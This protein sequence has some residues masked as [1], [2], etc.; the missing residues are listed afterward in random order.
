MMTFLELYQTL[1]GFT[2]FRLYSE[3]NLIYPPKLDTAIDEGAGGL[4]SLLLEET[5]KTLTIEG[6]RDTE[7]GL[8]EGKKVTA[9]DVKKQIR[10]LTHQQQAS[11]NGSATTVEVDMEVE[12]S[13]A[14]DTDALIASEQAGPSEFPKPLEGGDDA[15]LATEEDASNLFEGYYF[16][17]SRE[18]TR[19]TLEFI[20]RSFG[21]QVGWDAILGSGSPY[22]INDPRITHHIVDRPVPAG[23]PS[24][25]SN[26]SSSSALVPANLPGKRAYIQ[27]QWV[28]DCINNKKLL[29]TDV[30]GPGKILP[31][32]LSPFVDLQKVREQG[33][34]VPVEAGGEEIEM[35]EDESEEESEEEEEEV[36]ADEQEEE[37]TGFAEE[38]EAEAVDSDKEDVEE[39]AEVPAAAQNQP[40]P[41]LLAAAAN[42]EDASL[43]HAAEL[44][45]EA[46]GI[47]YSAFQNSLTALQKAS[48]KALKKQQ[49]KPASTLPYASETQE[50]N[51]ASMLLS[52]KQRKLFNKMKY[53]ENKRKEE[54]L[55]LE[56]K[57]RD[58]AKNE[59]KSKGK[60]AV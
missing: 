8:N 37:F 58:L 12:G 48:K 38:G 43:L 53:G 56:N 19:P 2:F 5:S 60:K 13:T 10:S 33:G 1:L 46:R 59:K 26:S 47:P 40:G 50:Q 49:P 27:P 23:M 22:T 25:S 57:K 29:P 39:V 18:V 16:Y 55:V 24:A 17:L 41:A 51:P 32:H 36:P 44:E 35:E 11:T 52:N 30:Y 7:A 4:G 54:A 3:I 14:A 6:K 15:V 31:P 28:V 34:Y 20:I 21:G 45:A 42:P 9:K